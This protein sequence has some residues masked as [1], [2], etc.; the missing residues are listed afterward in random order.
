MTILNHTTTT[1][2]PRR[3]FADLRAAHAAAVERDRAERAAAKLA[4]EVTSVEADVRDNLEQDMQAAAADDSIEGL[5]EL[6]RLQ[7]QR[8]AIETTAEK[9]ECDAIAARINADLD[10]RAQAARQAAGGDTEQGDTAYVATVAATINGAGVNPADHFVWCDTSEC[11]TDTTAGRGAFHQGHTLHTT[12]PT[13]P[14]GVTVQLACN[15][16]AGREPRPGDDGT[17]MVYVVA[18][19]VSLTPNAARALAS[20]LMFLAEEADQSAVLRVSSPAVALAGAR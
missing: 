16:L 5:R 7:A 12:T 11:D 2:Q 14:G 15:P 9:A 10:A 19:G 1:D 8:E 20:N 18:P 4:E 6:A 3:T 13:D 17:P